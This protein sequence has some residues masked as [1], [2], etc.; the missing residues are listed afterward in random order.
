M[1]ELKIK[2]VE[3]NIIESNDFNK[4]IREYYN[5][6]TYDVVVNLECE[7]DTEHLY[8]VDKKLMSV[9]NYKHLFETPQRILNDLCRSGVIEAG[10]YL[11]RVSW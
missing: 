7:N 5:K 1:T 6:P 4:F 11:V 9:Y 8:D 3:V 10:C 2:K